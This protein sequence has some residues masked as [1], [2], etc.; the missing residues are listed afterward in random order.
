[1]NAVETVKTFITAL[2][3]GDTEMIATIMADDF[4]AR[5]LTDHELDKGTFL[6]MQSELLDAMPDL[7]YNLSEVHAH[8]HLV[9]ALIMINGTQSN[10]LTLP[11]FNVQIPAT[12]LAISLPQ[13]PVEYILAGQQIKEMRVQAVQGG[14]LQGLLQQ[15]GGELR[16]APRIEHPSGPSYEE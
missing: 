2:Q 15:L 6:A 16:L 8:E 5:G 3:S 13:V 14:G 7:S 4:V 12:G 9:Q 11:V 10:D 1:M